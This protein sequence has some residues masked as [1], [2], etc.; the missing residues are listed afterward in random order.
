MY[1][2]YIYTS[3]YGDTLPS[4]ITSKVSKVCTQSLLKDPRELDYRFCCFTATLLLLYRCFTATL[5]LLY[6]FFTDALLDYRFES[7]RGRIIK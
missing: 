3:I 4:R 2:I 5:L 1:I 6:C 7:I